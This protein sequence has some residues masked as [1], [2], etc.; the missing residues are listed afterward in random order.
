MEPKIELLADERRIL[1]LYQ[2]TDAFAS[3]CGHPIVLHCGLPSLS[4]LFF[5]RG[6][7][8]KEGAALDRFPVWRTRFFGRHRADSLS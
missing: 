7:G 3:S 1:S 6:A 8:Q 2:K 4:R 5:R